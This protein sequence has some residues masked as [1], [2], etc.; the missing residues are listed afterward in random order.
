MLSTIIQPLKIDPVPLGASQM[1]T[2]GPSR[3]CVA[4]V[5]ICPCASR[6]DPRHERDATHDEHHGP[7]MPTVH[8]LR[9]RA[10]T[11]GRVRGGFP[12]PGRRR[13][14]VVGGAFRTF[15]NYPNSAA[16]EADADAGANVDEEE[17]VTG[18]AATERDITGVKGRKAKGRW[19]YRVRIGKDAHSVPLLAGESIDGIMYN[20]GSVVGLIHRIWA[21][22]KYDERTDDAWVF[23]ALVT[24][25]PVVDEEESSAADDDTDNDADADAD[26]DSDS[27]DS[28]AADSDADATDNDADADADANADAES[29]PD[30]GSADAGADGITNAHA[31]ADADSDSGS[32]DSDAADNDADADADRR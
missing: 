29:D 28:D 17:E 24:G 26:A 4:S 10:N 22:E 2:H 30:P 13:R 7:A 19:E 15:R 8:S 16:A 14:C 9:R 12:P 1:Q 11:R 6:R 25:L 31:D 5:Q 21:Y 3:R 32:A 20:G 18:E 27:A 23:L